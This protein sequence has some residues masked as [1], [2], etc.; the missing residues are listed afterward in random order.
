MKLRR[1]SPVAACDTICA[2]NSATSDF[3]MSRF[4]SNSSIHGVMLGLAAFFIFPVHDA[5][6]RRLV[7]DLSVWQIM[8]VRP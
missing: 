2:Q 7:K 1:D 8:F 6:V 5:L 3:L 4:K